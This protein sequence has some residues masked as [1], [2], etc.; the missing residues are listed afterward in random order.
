M[1]ELPTVLQIVRHPT[2]LYQSNKGGLRTRSRLYVLFLLYSLHMSRHKQSHWFTLPPFKASSMH[3]FTLLIHLLILLWSHFVLGAV[4]DLI[5]RTSPLDPQSNPCTWP[6][7]PVVVLRLPGRLH[8]CGESGVVTQHHQTTLRPLKVLHHILTRQLQRLPRL[9]CAKYSPQFGCMT[10]DSVQ[11]ST[12]YSSLV[13]LSYFPRYTGAQVYHR[14]TRE[15][16]FA[17]WYRE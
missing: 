11:S 2:F 12:S 3:L 7:A 9:F 15:P 17:D 8:S 1:S 10:Q 6:V 14:T 5:F 4:H 16:D 13:R